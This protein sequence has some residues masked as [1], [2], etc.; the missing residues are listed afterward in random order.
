MSSRV[1][2]DTEN[3]M[4]A[5]LDNRYVEVTRD[6][7]VEVIPLYVPEQNHF[8]NQH[9]Y[10][11]K[12]TIVN[13]SNQ[14]C[15]LLRRHWTIVDG[16]GKKEEVD[17]DGVIGQQP[18]LK[19]NESFEYSSFCPLATPTGSMR[20]HFEFRDDQDQSFLVKVPLFFL[21]PDALH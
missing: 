4:E 20:G 19:P 13:N 8:V 16:R 11:Y 9:L 7:S 21:R 5:N 15:Q 2:L 6:I 14:T 12:I 10:T 1:N 18:T 3:T 17:G